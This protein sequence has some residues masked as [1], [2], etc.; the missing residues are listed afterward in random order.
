[1]CVHDC[2]CVCM[3]TGACTWECKLEECVKYGVLPLSTLFLGTWPLIVPGA[4]L[5]DNKPQRSSH[6]HPLQHCVDRHM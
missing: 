1:M 2:T 6:L 5:V 4:K 3:G